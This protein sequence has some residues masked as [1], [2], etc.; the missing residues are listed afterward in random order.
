[1]FSNEI[2]AAQ[3]ALLKEGIAHCG[4]GNWSEIRRGLLPEWDELEIRLKTCR[5][6]GKQNLTS[7]TGWKGTEEDIKQE[8][9]KNKQ[10]GAKQ[11]ER[12]KFGLLVDEVGP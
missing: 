10:L 8:Y 6:F 1:M 7:Y 12:W 2:G 5:L 4:V 3:A 9:E 11:P